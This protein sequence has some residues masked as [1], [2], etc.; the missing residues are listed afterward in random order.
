MCRK[1][2][3]LIQNTFVHCSLR[4]HVVNV[5]W[6]PPQSQNHFEAR[7]CTFFSA[8]G[9]ASIPGLNA[10]ELTRH[11][12][13]VCCYLRSESESYVSGITPRWVGM[14]IMPLCE[15][16]RVSADHHHRPPGDA[17]LFEGLLWLIAPKW[18][19]FLLAMCCKNCPKQRSSFQTMQSCSF[20]LMH[21]ASIQKKLTHL[22]A[23]DGT[24]SNPLLHINLV[25][26]SYEMHEKGRS[27]FQKDACN[28]IGWTFCC[29]S[30]SEGKTSVPPKVNVKIRSR[31][32]DADPTAAST[33]ISPAV[34]SFSSSSVVFRG[35]L[36]QSLPGLVTAKRTLIGLENTVSSLARWICDVRF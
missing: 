24:L 36:Q 29:Q 20:F 23:P 31:S 35:N 25:K 33:L 19:T 28:V 9:L 2:R 26:S 32:D 8:D 7:W 1:S 4:L 16:K 11:E 12:E 3:Q 30:R 22:M 17:T 5:L 34:A 14:W 21:H 18:E 10:A 27:P 13:Q 15:C 6:L